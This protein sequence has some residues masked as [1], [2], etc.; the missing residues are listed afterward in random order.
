MFLKP[1]FIILF[2]SIFAIFV[3]SVLGGALGASFGFGFLGGP[4]PFISIAAETV[5]SV[6]SPFSYDL[7]NSTIMLW[8]AMLL[9]IVL[10]WFATRNI[11]E[12]PSGLQNIFELIFQFF[13]DTAEEA[14]G[15]NAKRFL[16]VVITIFLGVLAFNWMGIL[17]GVGSIGKI[18]TVEEWVHHHSHSGH[19]SEVG[20]DDHSISK[21]ISELCVLE[22]ESSHGFVVFDDAGFLSIMPLGRGESARAPLSAIGG[23]EPEEIH[24]IKKKIESGSKPEDIPELVAIQENIHSGKVINLYEDPSDGKIS[25]RSY[26]G[27]STGEL[28]PFFRG[29]STDVNTTLAIAIFSMIA[30]QFWGFSSLGF[31]GYGGKFINFSHGPINAFVGILELFGEFAKTISF[32]FRLFG[33]MFAGEIVLISMGFLLPLIGMIPFMGL[34][35]FVGVIQAFIFSMLTLVFGVMAVTAHEEHEEHD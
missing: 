28:I 35:L 9:L 19:C 23:Y 4:M 11:K 20:S 31:K 5:F 27:K 6:S 10:S 33:N 26:L 34:E 22:E 8:M 29:A 18:E 17:P 7:K 16:P 32:T 13:I 24:E 25:P 2:T 30:I 15:K 14:G 1:K 3:I 12:I 21:I